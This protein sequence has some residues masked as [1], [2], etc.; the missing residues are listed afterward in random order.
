MGIDADHPGRWASTRT[1]RAL[2]TGQHDTRVM[3][4]FCAR[5]AADD[6]VGVGVSVTSTCRWMRLTVERLQRL[7]LFDVVSVQV[8]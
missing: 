4:I 7:E 3:P 6:A 1:A 5:A 2:H 8:A